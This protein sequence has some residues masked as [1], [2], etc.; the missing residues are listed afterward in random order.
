MPIQ[1]LPLSGSSVFIESRPSFSKG[2]WKWLALLVAVS[3]LAFLVRP[4]RMT[5]FGALMA[6][7]ASF[8]AM[9]PLG[10]A[11][12]SG[13]QGALPFSAFISLFYLGFYIFP[14][15]LSDVIW[16]HGQ[17]MKLYTAGVASGPL[18]GALMGAVALGIG[19]LLLGGVVGRLA[20]R[21]LPGPFVAP[22][23]SRVWMM[24]VGATALLLHFSY[25][26]SPLVQKIPM[27]GQLS[28]PC[29]YLGFGIYFVLMLRRKIGLFISCL[30]IFIFVF[31]MLYG[32][33]S[34]TLANVVLIPGFLAFLAI[35]IRPRQTI[36]LLLV[37]GLAAVLLYR[38]ML[39]VRAVTWHVEGAHLTVIERLQLMARGVNVHASPIKNTG[40]DHWTIVSLREFAKRVN[41]T[42]V[43]SVVMQQSP[44]PVPFWKGETLEAL[45]TS[46][47]PRV[48]WR[49]K[50]EERWGH[51]FG[52]RYKFIENDGTQM[53][54]N[55]PWLVEGYANY[56]WLGLAGL[57]AFAGLILGILDRTLNP[58]NPA[59]GTLVFG[60]VVLF[61]LINQESNLTLGIGGLPL[62]IVFFLI[63]FHGSLW[64]KTKG[65]EGILRCSGPFS[66]PLRRLADDPVL[67]RW[68]IENL[69]R[70]RRPRMPERGTP[71]YLT[72]P[73]KE[74]PVPPASWCEIVAESSPMPV[75]LLGRVIDRPDC[76]LSADADS[77]MVSALHRFAWIPLAGPGLD[78]GVVTA[79]WRAWSSRYTQPDDG[80]AWEAYT[81]A[82]RVINILDFARRHGLPAPRQQTVETLAAHGQAILERL[83]YYGETA[84]CNHLANNGRGLWRLGLDLGMPHLAQAGADLLINEAGRL[85]LPSGILREG[86][87]HYHL[88]YL[89][90]YVDCWLAARR[91]GR[92]EEHVLRTIVERLYG[93][94]PALLLP[95]G[96]PLV[97]DVSPDSP[98]E[99]LSGLLPGTDMDNGW[100]A[101][102]D[103]SDR[104]ALAALRDTIP[105]QD[106]ALLA[107]DG[108][109]RWDHGP[110]SGLWHADPQGWTLSS[111]H[112]HED[113]GAA[114]L[115]WNGIPLF[116]DP[117]RG[118]YGAEGEAAAYRS[119]KAHGTLQ[120]DDLDPFPVDKPYYEDSF[121]LRNAGARPQMH[122]LNDQEVVV[123]HGGYARQDV[124]MV[125]RKWS[126]DSQGLRLEDSVDGRGR[127]VL[128]RRLVTP[129]PVTVDGNKA[130][131]V[132]DEHNFV[133]TAEVAIKI[134]P[135]KQWLAY[136][137]FKKAWAIEVEDKVSLPW[138][139]TL[140]VVMENT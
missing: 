42:A 58:A 139:G 108:W 5:L 1:D 61:P 92:P 85:F 23:Q 7:T 28:S 101:L 81:A 127:H 21:P 94:V 75:T 29:A 57:M 44:D 123:S 134:T 8:M 13:R 15:F 33:S 69:W 12:R 116:I 53:S 84:T 40:E 14:A 126:F 125:R 45:K 47:I 22:R 18:D 129:W 96:M 140:T 71:P 82:E 131:I 73:E 11:L 98:P 70:G 109:L 121:R 31:R 39:A 68:L 80:L 27:L 4:E 36:P 30:V 137:V 105:P 59:D 51:T 135:M 62:L 132:T 120:M 103:P 78:P 50:P 10:L 104:A 34:G 38:P 52:L 114:E 2:L 35:A 63:L 122:V 128:T 117:G 20:G 88:L 86:S 136:G 111:G 56:G 118:A 43:L 89:R 74:V 77:E 93:V 130:V 91:H 24:G 110:W 54:V 115:H 49:D 83:E 46:F 90:N 9:V 37:L 72:L 48:L 95:G 119:A 65:V 3:A 66:R 67:C 97:G 64:M 25:L 102:L 124:E 32:L 107:V 99:F 87:S 26:Y 60:G 17:E 133:V 19:C 138:T 113:L 100:T 112:G 55:M 41:A 106:R 6:A 76:F 16:P 79:C